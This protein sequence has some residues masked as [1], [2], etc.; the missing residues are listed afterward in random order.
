MM[1]S[2]SGYSPCWTE[3]RI[4]VQIWVGEAREGMEKGTTLE[5]T[6]RVTMR[7]VFRLA[8]TLVLVYENVGE[9]LRGNTLNN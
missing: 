7:V 8:Y 9:G 4:A 6:P 5:K 1:S 2:E 3:S